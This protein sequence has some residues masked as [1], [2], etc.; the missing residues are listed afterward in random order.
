[1]K[2]NSPLFV[3]RYGRACHINDHYSKFLLN[4]YGQV[5]HY[6]TGMTEMAVI[7]ADIKLLIEEDFIQNV[8][9]QLLNPPD[10]FF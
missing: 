9:E 2:R 7:E 6:Y 10:N 8:F 1:M 3:P 4:R 5:K